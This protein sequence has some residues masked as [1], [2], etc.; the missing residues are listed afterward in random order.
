MIRLTVGDNAL[1]VA[2]HLGTLRE[3]RFGEVSPLHV[4][5]WV[6]DAT[7]L[8]DES[9]LPVEREL[10]GD[11]FC[12]PFGGNDLDRG[13]SHGWS[14]NSAWE[15][16]ARGANWVT[17]EL[18]R[19]IQG[20]RLRKTL[21]LSGEAPVLHQTHEI[22]GGE[23]G[24][25]VAHH[26][27]LR[28]AGGGRVFFSEKRCAVTP[29]QPLEPTGVLSYPARGEDL[30]AFPGRD[31][32]IDLTRL[33]IG[34]GHE[35]FVSLIEAP[36]ARFGWTAVLR[37]AE[38][39]IVVML[40]DPRVLPLTMLWFSNC[41]REYA[42]WNGRHLGVLGIEDGCAA[43][44]DG[45]RAALG[46]NAIAREGVPTHLPLG[47]THRVEH[48]IAWFPRPEG[49]QEIYDVRLEAGRLTVVEQSGETQFIPCPDPF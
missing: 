19:R 32:E 34:E 4:A 35:D 16:V 9:L 11:F 1:A 31:G 26:P 41:G 27:M 47:G 45:H 10:A 23:G 39:D 38:Q 48:L 29:D 25:T 30:R 2:P 46:D 14:A 49:W 42:P 43:G 5:P 15:E 24:L 28:L 21:R 20:A 7:I 37:E 18:A 33:P 3:L 22:S 13:P 12:A 36:G 40:K 6:D 17:L 44:A 8:A